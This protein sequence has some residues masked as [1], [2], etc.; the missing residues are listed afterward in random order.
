[1]SGGDPNDTEVKSYPESQPADI[2]GPELPNVELLQ[3]VPLLIRRNS[4]KSLS[5]LERVPNS[6]LRKLNF[7]PLTGI[8]VG[9]RWRG[10]ALATFF[11]C[12]SE[13]LLERRELR[14][15]EGRFGLE[16]FSCQRNGIG[17]YPL[18]HAEVKPH[19][20]DKLKN[21]QG[22]GLDLLHGE[23]NRGVL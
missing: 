5:T 22:V 4:Q 20:K 23:G 1:M 13:L 21:V 10:L 15:R 19:I 16:T 17:L 2:H 18:R 8:S 14:E 7:E 11:N 3:K 12:Q 9:N 6:R